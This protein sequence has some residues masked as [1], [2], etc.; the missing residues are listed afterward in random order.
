MTIPGIDRSKARQP[1]R[2]S[3]FSCVWVDGKTD[4]ERGS[5]PRLAFNFDVSVVL[6]NNLVNDYQTQTRALMLLT[7]VFGRVEG[8]KDVF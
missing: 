7:L 6:L 2:G 4:D 5:S 8:I 1:L 3:T